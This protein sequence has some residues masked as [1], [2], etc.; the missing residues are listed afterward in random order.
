[1]T[2]GVLDL[3]LCLGILRPLVPGAAHISHNGMC[4]F[5]S[6]LSWAYLDLEEATAVGLE[7]TVVD[8]TH[9]VHILVS[10][11]LGNC[12]LIGQ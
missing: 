2:H 8:L 4:T 6:H 10:D 12:P 3:A 9:G 1:M 7:V 11:L 5:L